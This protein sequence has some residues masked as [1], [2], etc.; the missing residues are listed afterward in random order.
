MKL[1]LLKYPII[2]SSDEEDNKAFRTSRESRKRKNEIL[3]ESTSVKKIKIE[4]FNSPTKSSLISD[5]LITSTPIKQ[6]KKSQ[7]PT[8][9]SSL[10]E[11]ILINSKLMSEYLPS[12][13]RVKQLKKR[14]GGAFNIY[15]SEKI[16][17]LLSTS[18]D[19]TRKDCELLTIKCW[20]QF[21]TA[22]KA[23]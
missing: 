3:I 23:E 21:T 16:S 22:Q 4:S 13:K 10:P 9:N 19:Y 11:Q 5:Q 7:N 12:P 2:E 18:K 1:F 14:F 8:T 17:S 15:M 20:T 6:K